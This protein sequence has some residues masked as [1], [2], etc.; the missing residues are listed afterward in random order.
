MAFECPK[1]GGSLLYNIKRGKLK[2]EHC[3]SEIPVKDYN[4]KNQA[5]ETKDQYGVTAYVCRNC[6]AELLSPDNSIVG[7][8][9]YCGS[10]ATLDGRMDNELRPH[11]VI[12]FRKSK[13]E[14]Q[15]IYDGR[16]K[17]LL[18]LPREMKESSQLD[19]FRG[20]YIPFWMYKV[21][22]PGEINVEAIKERKS[23]NYYIQT[24]YD[25]SAKVEGDYQGIPYDASSCFDDTISDML[26]P[27]DKKDLKEFYPGYMAGF[28]ADRADVPAERY[29]AEAMSRATENA[30]SSIAARIGRDE[31]VTVTIPVDKEKNNKL[32]LKISDYYTAL[33]PVW[34]LTYRNKDRVAYSI[35][36]GQNGRMSS[37]MPVDLRSYSMGTLIIAAIAFAVLTFFVSMTARMALAL[38]AVLS[39][40]VLGLFVSEVVDIRDAENHVRDKGYFVRGRDV[41][42][43]YDAR[44]K[45][46]SRSGKGLSITTIVKWIFYVIF[47]TFVTTFIGA[48][49]S[50]SVSS[51]PETKLFMVMSL[52]MVPSIIMFIKGMSALR[53]V[54]EKR[55]M[56]FDLIAFLGVLVAFLISAWNPVDDIYYYIGCAICAF[57]AAVSSIATIKYYNLIAT[58]PIPS[59]F[60]REGGNDRY[61]RDEKNIRGEQVIAILLALAIGAV[62][63]FG[64]TRAA[65]AES[66]DY[67]NPNTGYK[68]FV[69]DEEDLLTDEEE[70]KLLEDMKPITEFGNVGFISCYA[71]AYSTQK[72]AEDRYVANIGGGVSGTILLI[73]MHYR[74]IQIASDGAMYRVITKSYANAITD[75]SYKYAS[76]GQYYECASDIFGQELRLLEGGKISQPMKHI[77]NFLVA[78]TLGV[79]IN[80][81]IV[82][83]QR[84][85]KA[86][87]KSKIFTAT[88]V[89][90]LAMGISSKNVIS[91]KRYRASSG[92]SGGGGGFSGGG[93]GGFSGGGGGGFS[94]GGGGGFSG[95]G[96]GHSF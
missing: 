86:V 7:Y 54:K 14:C 73:D 83:M 13:E 50:V 25:I 96:G 23:G 29:A 69:I 72:E 33:F 4:I 43:S 91:E 55:L 9:S 47:F 19:K 93:G 85:G 20:T 87:N 28:Y 10:E 51:N 77:S 94:G 92:G 67:I 62:G 80:Y 41:A 90:T 21:D 18:Y 6:G 66:L 65:Y 34:F 1:C 74:I 79:L 56:L 2:C 38:C 31:K 22:F 63:F 27:F 11:Y 32:N 71:N 39:A 24:T 95:G 68:A 8:C 46:R 35:V 64:S 30:F 16:M 61:E 81:M 48:F 89:S 42:M 58:R 17:N 3:S 44:K 78:I 53:Y 75:N 45:V 57:C 82:L 49:F 15:K 5:E 52:I 40:V 36:N 88:T 59:F 84:A 60:D 70:A 37:D 26:M 12:P 76:R